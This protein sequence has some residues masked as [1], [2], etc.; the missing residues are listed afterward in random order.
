M[1]ILK[2]NTTNIVSA[3]SGSGTGKYKAVGINE[4]QEVTKDELEYFNFMGMTNS[5]LKSKSEVEAVNGM[6]SQNITGN[7]TADRN[8]SPYQ[9]YTLS[10]GTTSEAEAAMSTTTQ[11]TAA[12]IT[13]TV[14]AATEASA[15]AQALSSKY[16]KGFGR[17]IDFT[18]IDGS[19]DDSRRA[20]MQIQG[21]TAGLKE[22][23]S[24]EDQTVLQAVYN[25]LIDKYTSIII[26]SLQENMQEKQHIM[27]TVGDS[28]AATFAGQEPQV[29]SI[30]GYLPFDG[31]K[32]NSWFLAFINAYRYFL[33]AS[34]L[35][36]YRCWLN[37][38]FPD[39]SSYKCYPISFTASLSSEQDNVIPFSMNAIV[40]EHPIN[41]AYGYSTTVTEPKN[42]VEE[43]KNNES[44]DTKITEI[45]KE[46]T[47]DPKEVG[48]ASQ[49][50]SFVQSVQEGIN[51]VLN[52]K[53]MQ[54]INKTLAVTNQV[55]GALNVLTGKSYGKRYF[56][57][58]IGRGSYD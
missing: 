39:F 52:S 1:A 53:T 16:Y 37:L 25:Q 47:K 13:A 19:D 58:K 40:M 21:E 17:L 49:K 55:H 54:T 8:G 51:S 26:L 42:T 14:D 2:S 22:A 10:D 35:A 48:K 32:D 34:R 12:A 44:A 36:K 23:I 30:S 57:G 15:A 27:P 7:R 5:T 29:V 56:S 43:V 46:T 33:R 4:Y 45:Q 20:Y 41:K 28:F 38:V 18:F 24:G 9:S 6:I 31:S 3:T 11:E 50:K